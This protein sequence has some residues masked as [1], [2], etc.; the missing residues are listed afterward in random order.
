MGDMGR[1]VGGGGGGGDCSDGCCGI[2]G[3]DVSREACSVW[4]KR[5]MDEEG[6]C[7][8]DGGCCCSSEGVWV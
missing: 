4:V 7:R 3:G 8:G 5:S 6:E 1:D 2:V